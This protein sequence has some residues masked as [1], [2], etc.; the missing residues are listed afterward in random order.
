MS[1]AASFKPLSELFQITISKSQALSTLTMK[2]QIMTEPDLI[3]VV[4]MDI[5]KAPS[6]DSQRIR[7]SMIAFTFRMV[8][9]I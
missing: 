2:W 1:M 6:W 8:I 3:M 7:K 5:S 9:F 4:L